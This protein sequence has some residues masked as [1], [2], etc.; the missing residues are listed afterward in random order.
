[1]GTTRRRLVVHGMVQGVGFRWSMAREADRRGARGWVRNRDD[2]A[3][4]AVVAGLV[5]QERVPA[6]VTWEK[7]AKDAPIRMV[8]DYRIVPRGVS[9][10]VGCNTF[11]T[12]NAYPGIFASLVTGN[13]V[14]V[15]PHP[16]AVHH[17]GEIDLDCRD[18]NTPL[19]GAAGLGG[20]ARGG[21]HRLARR[22]APVHARAA[23]VVPFHQRDLPA[24]LRQGAGQRHA[25]LPGADDG[26]FCLDGGHACF[27]RSGR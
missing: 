15:K 4:E 13:P 10:V 2:G 16:R 27:A 1:M 23:G 25:G 14:I 8:K 3:V 17:R 5:E 19:G 22:A 18:A 21:D 11:P 9:L 24:R 20:Q 6:S 7:P 26:G 12:W